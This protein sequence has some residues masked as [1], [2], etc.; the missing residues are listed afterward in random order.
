MSWLR[1]LLLELWGLF[2]DDGRY[3]LAIVA[4]LLLAWRAL[5]LLGFGGGWNAPVFAAGLL[6]ILVESVLRRARR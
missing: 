6:A 1:K 2:V 3:A 4:W 5:P